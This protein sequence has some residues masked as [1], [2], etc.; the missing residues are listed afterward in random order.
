MGN[1]VG[2][3]MPLISYSAED[4]LAG[5]QRL[6][7]R[8]RVWNRGL[9]LI[10][11]FDLLVLMPTWSRLQDALNTLIAEIFPCS[12]LDL[13]PEWEETLGLPSACTGNLGNLQ[14][15]QQA[16]CVKFTARGGQ[17]KAYFISLA[18][19]LG[20]EIT[21]TEFAPFRAG[22]NRAGDPVYGEGWALRLADHGAGADHLFPGRTID[23]R[24]AAAHLGK[25]AL[26]VH[27]GRDQAGSYGAALW[28]HATARGRMNA[29]AANE[30][31]LSVRMTVA[32]WNQVIAIL[33]E[34]P[35]RVVAPLIGKIHG[36]AMT[37]LG[38]QP[39]ALTGR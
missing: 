27:H 12:T 25:P 23:R 21:I 30:T 2:P 10:Q 14:E 5:F 7:P 16:V 18:E 22:I 4:Y 37:A 19:T 39:G 34:H 28:L 6:L 1:A 17:S 33:S 20:Y 3:L 11:D 38:A 13:L 26:R 9:E 36:Q 31:P 8:G 35:F 29:T 15:R 24:R 32:E